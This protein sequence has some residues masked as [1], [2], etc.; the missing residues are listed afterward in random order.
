MATRQH[1]RQYSD[2]LQ[3]ENGDAVLRIIAERGYELAGKIMGLLDPIRC[4][5]DKIWQIEEYRAAAKR[6]EGRGVQPLA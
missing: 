6:R 3:T 4:K 5:H 1:V 2:T